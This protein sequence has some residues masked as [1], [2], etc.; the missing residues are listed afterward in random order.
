[1]SSIFDY[2][3][4]KIFWD[5]P[6]GQLIQQLVRKTDD[7]LQ[8]CPKVSPERLSACPPSSPIVAS[9]TLE[10][11]VSGLSE[12]G[13]FSHKRWQIQD[14]GVRVKQIPAY[15]PLKDTCLN[16]TSHNICLIACSFI[17]CLLLQTTFWSWETAPAGEDEYL[18]LTDGEPL[19]KSFC[20]QDRSQKLELSRLP[21]F[22]DQM[23]M[24]F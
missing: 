21:E 1:M 12:E 2:L 18:I 17:C 24:L 8:N 16:I 3:I 6:P 13:L 11:W 14:I 23:T 10:K 15:R 5:Q 9:A 19:W 20:S 4:F 22:V 7:F